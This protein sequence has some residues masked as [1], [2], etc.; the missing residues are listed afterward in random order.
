MAA[1]SGRI[2]HF[3]T[4][5]GVDVIIYSLP[6]LAEP[7]R[8]TGPLVADIYLDKVTRW[9]DPAIATLNP[10]GQLPHQSIVV[11]HRSDGSGTTYVFTDYLSKV[12]PSGRARSAG[13]PRSLGQR[14][15]APMATRA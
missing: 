1:L 12:S 9:D 14:D 11:C 3:P 4:V 5:L 6:A 15:S 7:L 2:L 10:R 13:A 8:F